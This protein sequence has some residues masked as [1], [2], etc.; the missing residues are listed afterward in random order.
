MKLLVFFFFALASS[1]S[2][3]RGKFAYSIPKTGT[4]SGEWSFNTTA[5]KPLAAAKYRE[6]QKA[7]SKDKA[8]EICPTKEKVDAENTSTREKRKFPKTLLVF[9]TKAE[10][11]KD[12]TAF[13]NSDN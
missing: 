4:D 6:L 2:A 10:C 3:A 12:R 1:A 8:R 13:L 7:C 9:G 5:C 11:D